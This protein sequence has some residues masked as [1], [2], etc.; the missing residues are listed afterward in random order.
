MGKK[1]G[2]GFIQPHATPEGPWETIGIDFITGLPEVDGNAAIL[3]VV[4]CFSKWAHFIAVPNLP[5][6]TET[7]EILFNNVFK[8]HGIPRKIISDRGT[9]FNSEI[10]RKLCELMGIE[11]N[12]SSAYHPQTDGLTEKTNNSIQKYL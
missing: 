12:L 2:E 3:T 5:G 9:Q 4:D 7:A 6:S 11:Q 1:S 8:I 10:S